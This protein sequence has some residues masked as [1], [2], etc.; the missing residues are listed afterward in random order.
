MTAS[1]WVVGYKPIETNAESDIKFSE[2]IMEGKSVRSIIW[3]VKPVVL[4]VE[5][6]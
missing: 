4:G 5:S 2:Q 1:E 3:E 6:M